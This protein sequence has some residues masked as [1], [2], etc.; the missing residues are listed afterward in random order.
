MRVHCNDKVKP[1][2]LLHILL[3][4]ISG[5]LPVFSQVP[6]QAKQLIVAV[7]PDWS[8]PKATL[9]CWQRDSA[10]EPWQRAFDHSWPVNLGRNGMA[11]GRGV[12]S[13]TNSKVGWKM[14]KD[15]K[16]PAGVFELGPL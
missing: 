13:P 1:L 7:A 6:S 2:L 3:L 15:G 12:F 4:L 16:A 5:H 11:W 10:S 9:Q 14:E 8:S